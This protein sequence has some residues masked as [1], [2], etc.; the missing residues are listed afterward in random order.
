MEDLRLALAGASF[1]FSVLAFLTGLI[2]KA[3]DSRYLQVAGALL[4]SMLAL[5]ATS[6]WVYILSVFII[7]TFIT[8]LDF[9][10]NI[11]AL[12]WGREGFWKYRIE[13]TKATRGEKAAKIADEA[14]QF[15]LV[16]PVLP[17]SQIIRN[18]LQKEGRL[19]YALRAFFSMLPY[20]R[21]TTN[22]AVRFPGRTAVID[23]I[24]ETPRQAFLIEVKTSGNTRVYRESIAQLRHH[25]SIYAAVGNK[26]VRGI[27]VVPQAADVETGREDEIAILRY[28]ENTMAFINAEAIYE[29][30]SE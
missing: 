21:F 27:L 3:D 1:F 15:S 6:G 16:S 28:D 4:V 19:L 23:A 14:M 8:Q 18:L 20:A 24:A 12:I 5:M 2:W 26:P 17:R 7:A 22:V 9:L 25:I 29:W 13:V 30:I 11:A 10:E